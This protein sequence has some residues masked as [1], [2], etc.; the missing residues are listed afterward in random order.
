[1]SIF[2]NFGYDED[3]FES[4]ETQC[5]KECFCI[6]DAPE[7]TQ[8]EKD[9]LSRLAKPALDITRLEKYLSKFSEVFE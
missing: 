5:P 4:V 3:E 9:V 2:F 8:D 7:L 6:I 1:M